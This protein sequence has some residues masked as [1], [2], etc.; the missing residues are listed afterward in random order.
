MYLHVQGEGCWWHSLLKN[1]NKAQYLPNFVQI[2]LG[3][4]M[5]V[6]QI[7]DDSVH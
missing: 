2:A 5:I 6:I 7:L 4:K 1:K 3:Y